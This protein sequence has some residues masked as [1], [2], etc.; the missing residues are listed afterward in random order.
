M[1][2]CLKNMELLSKKE[3]TN[4]A[5]VAGHTKPKTDWTNTDS[6]YTERKLLVSVNVPMV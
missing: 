1:K 2:L 4:A 5:N 3:N 6:D